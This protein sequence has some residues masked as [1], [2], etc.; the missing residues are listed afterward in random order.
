MILSVITLAVCAAVIQV[1]R[2]IIHLKIYYVL[3]L[4]SAQYG[5]YRFWIAVT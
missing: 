5:L 2:N 4:I 3:Q 1:R